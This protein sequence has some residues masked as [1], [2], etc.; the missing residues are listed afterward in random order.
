MQR[1]VLLYANCLV[2][3]SAPSCSLSCMNLSHSSS[4]FMFLENEAVIAVI[5]I[6][7]ISAKTTQFPKYP[8]TKKPFQEIHQTTTTFSST[9][10]D[11]TTDSIE[12]SSSV[13]TDRTTFPNEILH[14]FRTMTTPSAN[15]EHENFT[16]DYNECFFNFCE[17]CPPEQG[18]KGQKG[19]RGL[20]GARG[21]KGEPG[22]R[23]LPGPAGITGLKGHQ[24]DKGDK[25]DKGDD[26]IIGVPGLPGKHGEKG[27]NGSKG[28]KGNIGFPGFKGEK[29]EKG[30][31]CENG[32]KG[33]KGEE[34]PAGIMGLSGEKGEKGEKGEDGEKGECGI[35]GD[36]GDRGDQGDDGMKGE[37][38]DKG[39]PGM[40]GAN[41]ANGLD[42]EAGDPGPK[43]DK[44]D[45][46][47]AGLPGPPGAR[48]NN[49]PKGDRGPPGM[50]GDRGPRGFK[51]A[52][53]ENV[54]IK[55]SSFSVGLSPSKSFP[56]PG[57]PVKFDKIFYNG[58][59]D[60]DVNN[61]KFNCSIPGVYLF[62]YHVT[63]RNRPLR[64]ALVVSGIR[65]LRTRDS[66]YGQDIDQASNL[67]LVKLISG[68]QV[69][70]ETLRDW[71]GIYASSEDDSTFS[72]F[73]LYP[74]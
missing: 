66:L 12:T 43:G 13:L 56:P 45:P 50:K 3:A 11:E 39:D 70:L 20:P 9:V 6:A 69:W 62:T 7:H 40:D 10:T 34:G 24:G 19:D 8:F 49:G 63:V 21:E 2:F 42:G 74:D 1:E 68:D 44:G 58:E 47:M 46:G 57:F 28:D 73:L 64:V 30:E 23:G 59:N 67:I 72:G 55:R 16:L 37:K 5:I 36:K 29:G 65:K 54:V 14:A 22:I 61:G 60:Y 18:P 51:G 4:V 15:G 35:S 52:R 71:N 48:G 17:C 25:G 38:G 41:G 31:I 27:E 33:D 26:G 32:T 53:G